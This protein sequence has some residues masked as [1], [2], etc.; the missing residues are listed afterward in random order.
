MTETHNFSYSFRTCNKWINSYVPRGKS[1]RQW[2][3]E[4]GPRSSSASEKFCVLYLWSP[5]S[6]WE[7]VTSA[8]QGSLL[9]M[10]HLSTPSFIS[11]IRICIVTR[12]PGNSRQ[13]KAWRDWSRSSQAAFS[14]FH[15]EMDGLEPDGFPLL[16]QPYDWLYGDPHS[17]DA[18]GKYNRKFWIGHQGKKWD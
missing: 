2:V 6:G 13:L 14:G 10:Q 3:R 18:K 4:F 1:T 7:A 17:E 5:N 11:W 8:S 12:S 9:R 16:L 15:L